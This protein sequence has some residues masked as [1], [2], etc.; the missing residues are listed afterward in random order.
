MRLLKT[1]N[2]NCFFCNDTWHAS[3]LLWIYVYKDSPVDEILSSDSIIREEHVGSDNEDQPPA[4]VPI[5]RQGERSIQGGVVRLEGEDEHE[6][7]RDEIDRDGQNE[8]LGTRGEHEAVAGA[9]ETAE[10]VTSDGEGKRAD[11]EQVQDALEDNKDVP[12]PAS[13]EPG[14]TR[15]QRTAPVHPGDTPAEEDAAGPRYDEGFEASGDDNDMAPPRILR[16][17]PAAPA[18]PTPVLSTRPD[19]GSSTTRESPPSFP[20][21]SPNRR[22]SVPPPLRSAPASNVTAAYEPASPRIATTKRTSMPPPV[23]AVPQPAG[24]RAVLSPPPVPAPFVVAS[25]EVVEEPEEDS[26]EP[27]ASPSPSPPPPPPRRSSI[28]ASAPPPPRKPSLPGSP[29]Q[30]PRV[31]VSWTAS[32]QHRRASR[33]S[34]S[35]YGEMR[36]S[37]VFVPPPPPVPQ[38]T[39]ASPPPLPRGPDSPSVPVRKLPPTLAS[40]QDEEHEVLDD[41]DGG[42]CSCS[43]R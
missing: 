14:H 35:S 3:H 20:S 28:Q 11:G 40:P 37:L 43:C 1:V 33:E 24:E 31:P 4:A 8:T 34:T 29:P 32:S 19:T 42:T 10:D 23:R 39:A 36:P 18:A 30:S 13:I 6:A 2:T 16:P 15:E 38:G 26:E 21:P 7:L 25:E 5:H 41:S 12:N 17:L 27:H 9:D 22:V